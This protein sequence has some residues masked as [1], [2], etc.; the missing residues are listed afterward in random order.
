MQFRTK[1][2][3]YQCMKVA[4]NIRMPEGMKKAL[5]EIA[6]SEF[7]SLNSVIL[8]FLNEKLNSKGIDWREEDADEA[9]E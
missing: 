7:R 9:K 6:T 4:V 2:F 1:K 3:I 8:Q 5:D